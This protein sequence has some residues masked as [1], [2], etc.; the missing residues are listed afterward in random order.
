M[1]DGYFVGIGFVYMFMKQKNSYLIVTLAG[2]LF[3]KSVW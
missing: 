3:S 1:S 2:F